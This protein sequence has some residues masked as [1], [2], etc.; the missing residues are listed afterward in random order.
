MVPLVLPLPRL[1]LMTPGRPA[2]LPLVL[3]GKLDAPVLGK[4]EVLPL[5]LLPGWL[6]EPESPGIKPPEKPEVLPLGTPGLVTTLAP[7]PAARPE[8]TVPVLP[9]GRAPPLD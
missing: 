4:L 9:P 6:L 1:P 3:L 7:V 5:V 2:V 8:V